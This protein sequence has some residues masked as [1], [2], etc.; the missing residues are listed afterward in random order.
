MLPHF[1]HAWIWPITSAL[2]I[3]S[4]ERHVTQVIR[5]GCKLRLPEK[6]VERDSIDS[7]GMA[8]FIASSIIPRRGDSACYGF[9]VR[10]AAGSSLRRSLALARVVTTICS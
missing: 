4:R 1:G 3:F 8:Y 6:A 10:N 9:A 7:R 2:R 5:N